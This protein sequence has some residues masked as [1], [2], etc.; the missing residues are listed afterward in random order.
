MR[1]R[2]LDRR[3]RPRERRPFHRLARV[4]GRRIRGLRMARGWTQR[5]AA[6]RIG[7]G[8]AGM[9][10]M[11]FGLANPSLAVLVS[12]ARAFGVPLNSLLEP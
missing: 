4:L 3:R 8:A 2:A 5:R 10:R 6:L 11:E 9:R 1:K 7:I 12:V